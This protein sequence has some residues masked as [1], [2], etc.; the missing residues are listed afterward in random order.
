[1]AGKGIAMSN[2]SSNTTDRDH[3]PTAAP[4]TPGTPPGVDGLEVY[5]R[6]AETVGMVPSLRLKDN[7]VQTVA[8]L[9]GALL[10]AAVAFGISRSKGATGSDLWLFTGLG[11]ALG[12]I[13]FGIVSGIVLMFIGWARAITG[14]RNNR[15]G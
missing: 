5:N 14:W 13:G 12:F 2:E 8:V 3:P 9:V 6:V 15:R 11:A 10:G 4:Q 1:M 7:L